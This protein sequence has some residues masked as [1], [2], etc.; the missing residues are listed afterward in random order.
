MPQQILRTELANISADAAANMPSVS[1]MKRNIRKVREENQL[2]PNPLNR[3]EIPLLP[4]AF[5]NTLA[6]ECFLIFDSSV[7]DPNRIFI[8]ASDIGRQLLA[9]S[10]H[11]Y[12]DGTF[13]VCPEV[14]FLYITYCTV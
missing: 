6:G 12:A 14:F 7:G 3:Q 10:E 11:W 13:K 2:P 9:D 1:T 5:R 4:E 8:F